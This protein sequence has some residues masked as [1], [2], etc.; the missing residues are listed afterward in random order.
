MITE[1]KY[2]L[3]SCVIIFFI[4]SFLGWCYELI[5]DLINKGALIN[6]GFF[7]G[8][9]LPIYGTGS[10]CVI[11]LLK[12]F[13]KKPL[14][15]FFLSMVICSTIEFFTS[16]IL[17][18]IYHKLWW[19]YSNLFLNLNGRIALGVAVVFGIFCLILNYILAPFF[20][21]QI[22]KI[23]NKIQTIICIVLITVF[24]IDFSFSIFSPHCGFVK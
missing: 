17:E 5:L 20:N 22:Y 16:Y 19:D 4:F 21:K 24:I 2:T 3:K 11:V 1:Q 23:P 9:Y 8:P 13:Y 10:L 12:K 15:T 6:L 18:L 7:L 14:L